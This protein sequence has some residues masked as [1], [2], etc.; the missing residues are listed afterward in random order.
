[1]TR[2]PL[3]PAPT[4][5]I[6]SLSLHDALPIFPR[7]VTVLRGN[8]SGRP[9]QHQAKRRAQPSVPPRACRNLSWKEPLTRVVA[10]N[11][12]TH[13]LKTPDRK[14][15]RLNSSHVKISYAVFCLKK[16]K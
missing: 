2:F 1:L 11:L 5:H 4:A 14:S 7:L 8:R 16:K 6:Y 3:P 9:E 12:I 10:L 15:T 13:G